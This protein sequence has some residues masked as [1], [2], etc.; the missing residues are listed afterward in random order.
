MR[1]V[2]LVSLVVAGCAPCPE[3]SGVP[4]Q[5]C[6]QA[7][8]G[9]LVADQPFTLSV[10][11]SGLD[12]VSC[13]VSVDGGTLSLLLTGTSCPNSGSTNPVVFTVQ[14]PCAVPALPAGSYTLNDPAR[15][16]FSPGTPDAGLAPCP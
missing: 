8:A 1:T 3:R 13:A 2:L 5:I 16:T 11:S 14:V 15:T 10:A 9:A 6:H 7:D 12:G 4:T